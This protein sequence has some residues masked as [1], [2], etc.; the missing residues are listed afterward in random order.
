MQAE[1][2]FKQMIEADLSAQGFDTRTNEVEWQARQLENGERKATILAIV[3]KMR[4]LIAADKKLALAK[5]SI[6]PSFFNVP[7]S[8]IPTP[9][10]AWEYI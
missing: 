2:I 1:E 10:K 4:G 9:A 3:T 8:S 6:N 7:Y 5:A